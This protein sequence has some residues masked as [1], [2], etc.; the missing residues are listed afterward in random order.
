MNAPVSF[1]QRDAWVLATYQRLDRIVAPAFG[2]HASADPAP[3]HTRSTAAAEVH[4]LPRQLPRELG[5]LANWLGGKNPQRLA[6]GIRLALLL[7]YLAA[8]LRYEPDSENPVHKAVPSSRARFPLDYFLLTANGG[9]MQAWLYEPLHHGLRTVPPPTQA[10]GLQPGETAIACVARAWRYAREYGEFAHFPCVLE[11]G[12]A[13]SAMTYLAQALDMPVARL[14]PRDALG[15]LCRHALES[16]QFAAVLPLSAVSLDSAP[17]HLRVPAMHPLPG[18]AGRFPLL[19]AMQRLFDAGASLPLR[20]PAPRAGTSAI[21]EIGILETLRRRSAGNNMQG[22]AAL[23]AAPPPGMPGA[24]LATWDALR[25][26]R[27]GLGAEAQ[28]GV[29]LAWLAPHG[30]SAPGLYGEDGRPGPWQA[31]PGELALRLEAMLPYPHI[32]IN[33]ASLSAIAL[34]V[35]NPAAAIGHLGDCA[36]RELHLAAGA[37]AQDFALAAAAHGMFARPV[38]MMREARLEAAVALPGQVIYMVLCGYARNANL[39]MELW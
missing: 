23:V 36:L 6:D 9:G 20:P 29:T 28:V 25:R 18:L 16:V 27:P 32:R 22:L 7:K 14:L 35:C 30:P 12:Q 21:P 8:P 13:F 37:T 1:D 2:P 17:C 3:V 11:A 38:R 39:T 26:Q 31:P 5:T 4:P 34:I 24:L 15:G 19:P 10:T 33:V